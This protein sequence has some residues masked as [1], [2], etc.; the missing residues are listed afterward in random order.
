M[1]WNPILHLHHHPE[2]LIFCISKNAYDHQSNLAQ[3]AQR[4]KD[5]HEQ[6]GDSILKRYLIPVLAFLLASTL[7]AGIYFGILTWAQGWEYASKQFLLNRWYVVPIWIGFGVQAALYTI[8]RFRLFIPATTTG[9]AGALMGTSGGTSVT[10]MV[11]CCLHHVADVL[12]ILGLSA[13]ATFLTRYQRPFMLVGLGTEIIGAF[14]MLV[15]IYRE[16][17][18]ILPVQ[19]LQPIPLESK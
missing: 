12:P 2:K 9:H 19:K 4:Y 13:A 17:Q 5:Y 6:N 15:V 10:A 7:I 1:G 11:A 18:K 3:D 16:R 8:L 14:I